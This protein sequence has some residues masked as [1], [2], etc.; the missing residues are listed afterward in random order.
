MIKMEDEVTRRGDRARRRARVK[1]PGVA[2]VMLPA[3][4]R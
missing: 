1:A 4:A 2:R 3:L